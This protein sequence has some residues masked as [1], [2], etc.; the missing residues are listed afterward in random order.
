MLLF[1]ELPVFEYVFDGFKIHLR[2]SWFIEMLPSCGALGC[3]MGV[4]NQTES[5]FSSG[6][7][8]ESVE[9]L[10][11]SNCCCAKLASGLVLPC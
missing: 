1:T 6:E 9:N 3:L 2:Q 5:K 10:F 7:G 8:T 11:V 4:I